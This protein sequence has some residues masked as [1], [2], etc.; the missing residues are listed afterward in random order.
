MKTSMI[1]CAGLLA[2][3]VACCAEAAVFTVGSDATCTHANLQA[4]VDAAEQSE[5][6]DEIRIAVG[7]Y[8]NQAVVVAKQDLDITG[9]YAMCQSTAPSATSQLDGAGGA[10]APVLAL[11]GS[12]DGGSMKV[13]V[14]R[15]LLS[16][17]DNF[18]GTGGGLLVYGR[19]QFIVTTTTITG[20]VAESGGGVAVVG[21]QGDAYTQLI[22]GDGVTIVSNQAMQGGGVWAQAAY[23]RITGAKTSVSGNHATA[24]QFEYG[25]GG[26]IF[27]E[28][29]SAGLAASASADIDGGY[30]KDGLIAGNTAEQKGGGLYVGA[31]ANV[32]LFTSSAYS[33]LHMSAN[34]SDAYGGAIY[35][36]GRDAR[37]TVW[38]GRIEGNH[39]E[40]GG[41]AVF[42]ANGAQVAFLP[43]R[44]AGAPSG[45]VECDP[46]LTCNLLANNDSV[47]GG[48]IYKNGAVAMVAN[49]DP[50]VQS[51]VL[52]DSATV[53][54]HVGAS[55]FADNC[56]LQ[57]P[58]DVRE[59]PM[60]VIIINSLIA[61]NIGA[62]SAM[63]FPFATKASCVLCT[64][65]DIRGTG[66]GDESEPVIFDT[67]G[68]LVLLQSIVWEPRRAVLGPMFPAGIVAR[69]LIVHDLSDFPAQPDLRDDDPLFMDTAAGDYHLR[70]DSPALDSALDDHGVLF[71]LDGNPRVIDLPWV[72]NRPGAL[73]LGAYEHVK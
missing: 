72:T 16:G 15:L 8:T 18:A 28:G 48:F 7:T 58:L 22:L 57:S 68:V 5:G 24:N 33:P 64:I 9:G 25:Q 51:Q 62:I 12:A 63:H 44:A 47:N 39:S 46:S 37:V 3:A 49:N 55:L 43:A 52:L 38:E 45:T 67:R 40:V 41:G 42:A 30:S 66:F 32:R 34:A 65:A 35:A 27:I 71:D 61:P 56:F 53:S 60:G 17:G 23:L 10:P 59:N 4:A 31:D 11:V 26:G 36:S 19:G 21:T 2:A 14:S 70:P 50:G 1:R 20:N 6:A 73:D 54:G 13:H 29:G 69:D